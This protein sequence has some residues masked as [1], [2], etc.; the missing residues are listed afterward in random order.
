MESNVVA[1]AVFLGTVGLTIALSFY[2]RAH[3]L[4]GEGDRSDLSG[5]TLNRWLIGLSAGAAANSGFIV[6]AAVGLGYAD[7]VRWIMLPVAWMLGD[8]VFWKLFPGKLNEYSRHND[9]STI[10]QL[11]AV[12]TDKVTCRAI[13]V[14]SAIL[15][16]TGLI[17]YTASQWI[18][19]QKLLMAASGFS[20]IPVIIFFG[21]SLVV[22]SIVGGFRGSVYADTFQ[23]VLSLLSTIVILFS[24]FTVASGEP[25]V[26][27]SNLPPS[28]SD[29]WNILPD[30]SIGSLIAFVLGFAM[31]SIGFGLGQPQISSRY[32]AGSSP[33]ETLAAKWIYIG[34]LQ[35]T[36]ISMTIFGITLRGV[37]PGL[38]DPESGLTAFAQLHMNQ[39]EF[40]LV[41]AFIFAIIASTINSIVVAVA[42][43]VHKDIIQ[44]G[45]ES[46]QTGGLTPPYIV[47][48][49]A[50]SGLLI[51]FVIPGSVF[52]IAVN[53]ISKIAAGIA[54]P[55]II[56]ILKINHD[57]VSI[58]SSMSAG[59]LAAFLWSG[60][61]YSAEFNESGIGIIVGFLTNA[62]VY[63]VRN[64]TRNVNQGIV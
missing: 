23:A 31:A 10:S 7:G 26:F 37:M 27:W 53:S 36:W 46:Q 32:F 12:G 20:E 41:I 21:S 44:S 8:L 9:V 13:K 39:L 64:R 50:L 19:G 47:G 24:I 1:F 42:Q 33:N 38:T 14:S 17:A 35:F 30:G 29:F 18:A 40:G 51:S 54:G 48:I 22:Y 43:T 28:S 16:I 2:A 15:L 57:G 5:R 63:R 61:G 45:R 25:N 55:V 34:F 59:V 49:V 60:L 56:K 6:S 52:S 4:R 58:L 62:V 3:D 11:L